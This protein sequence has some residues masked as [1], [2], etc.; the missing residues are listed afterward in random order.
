MLGELW[1]FTDNQCFIILFIMFS[2]FVFWK[3]CFLIIFPRGLQ[4]SSRSP[5]R[6]PL[7]RKMP[8]QRSGIWMAGM[9]KDGDPKMGDA[10]DATRNTSAWWA[11]WFF[12]MFKHV[13]TIEMTSWAMSVWVKMIWLVPLKM[14]GLYSPESRWIWIDLVQVDLIFDPYPRQVSPQCDWSQPM[15]AGP[16]ASEGMHWWL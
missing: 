15:G 8:V 14:E 13:I 7:L 10:T 16:S 4:P 2:P 6:W 3:P 11:W 9:P 12:H 5:L 1:I